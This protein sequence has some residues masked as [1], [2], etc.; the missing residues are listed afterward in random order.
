M[1]TIKLHEFITEHRDELI[2]RC[3]AKVAS[4]TSPAPTEAEI[5]HGVPLFLNQLVGELRGGPSKTSKI[6][7]DAGQH[8][9]ELLAHGFTLGQVVHD[10]GDICQSVTDLSVELAAPISSAD[11]RTLNRCLDDA[12]AGAVTQY[13]R[14]ED[15]VRDGQSDEM[16]HL[17]NTAIA[18]FEVLQ[19]GSVGIAGTT[20]SLVY[21]SLLSMRTLLD[22]AARLPATAKAAVPKLPP[23]SNL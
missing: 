6:H 15:I 17:L 1:A 20:G 8:G 4:R 23:T 13:A 2:G 3:R 14:G 9:K 5:T 7:A 16:R 12:I 21:R 22:A 19:T 11:F 10:Y 18:A